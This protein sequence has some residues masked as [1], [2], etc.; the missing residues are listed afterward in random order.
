MSNYDIE[1]GGDT[2]TG[3]HGWTGP[4]KENTRGKSMEVVCVS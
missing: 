2:S 3:L 1:L 4:P